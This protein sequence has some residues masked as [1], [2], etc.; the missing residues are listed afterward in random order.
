MIYAADLQYLLMTFVFLAVGIPFYLR[1]R[2]DAG[3]EEMLTKPERT[4]AG[5]IV[6]TALLAVV[7]FAAGKITL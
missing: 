6:L 5:L 3:A 4:A 2:K 1:A 7:L